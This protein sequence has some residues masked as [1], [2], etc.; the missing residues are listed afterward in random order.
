MLKLSDAIFILVDVQG[1][2]ANMMHDKDTLFHNLQILV[3]AMIELEIPIVWAEQY[4]QGLGDTIPELKEIL[5]DYQPIS[6]KT[7]SVCRQ[8]DLNEQ[9]NNSGKK[10]AVVAGI[11]SHVC[12]Y[13]TVHDLL[14]QG[15]GVTLVSDAISSRIKENKSVG[16][17][18]MV[19]EGARLSSLEMILFELLETAENDK[20]R[21]ISNLLK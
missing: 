9:I 13:Q 10:E 20:F 12:V 3:K 6:K 14:S 8:K 19:S 1:K 5:S 2:L 11:E 4:P 17:Q 15:F 16:I 21:A 7:F 18:R